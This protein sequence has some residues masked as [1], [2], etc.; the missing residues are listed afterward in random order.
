MYGDIDKIL[1]TRILRWLIDVKLDNR[2]KRQFYVIM[3][4]L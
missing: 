1:L 3:R 2:M 4:K